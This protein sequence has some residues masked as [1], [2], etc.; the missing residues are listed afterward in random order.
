MN[1]FSFRIISKYS[2]LLLLTIILFNTHANAQKDWKELG[3]H[4]IKFT[5]GIM[6]I[7]F[8]DPRSEFFGC[9]FSDSPNNRY[10]EYYSKEIV[11]TPAF[12][13][14]Y[15]HRMR[16][17]FS[18]EINFTYISSYEKYY[19]IYTDKIIFTDV[20]NSYLFTPQA[21]FRWVTTKYVQ[22]YSA[23]GLG[24]GFYTWKNKEG[25]NGY[26]ES[27]ARISLDLNY[28]GI[29]VGRKLFGFTELGIGTNGILR[30]G[31]GYRF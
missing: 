29:S 25:R 10:N 30:A 6:P 26:N 31:I 2:L 12:T 23:I 7:G 4:E 8:F 13:V 28:F 11:Y 14:S 20:V 27:D 15:S 1:Y 9:C 17:W 21:K 24:V 16:R 19:D 18:W 22:C 5:T 3:R